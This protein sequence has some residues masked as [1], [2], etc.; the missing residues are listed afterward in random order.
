MS[1]VEPAFKFRPDD[2]DAP[3]VPDPAL[4]SPRLIEIK[5]A[6]VDA[7]SAVFEEKKITYAEYEKFR[8]VLQTL[9]EIKGVHGWFDIW[10]AKMVDETYEDE[11]VGTS[12]QPEGP[13][14]FPGAPSLTPVGPDYSYALPQREGEPGTP[15]IIS[16]QVRSLDGTPLA[17]AEF[18]VWQCADTGIY[19]NFGMDDQPEFNL[20]GKFRCD[21]DGRYELR[22]I[23]PVPYMTPGIPQILVDIWNGLGKAHFRPAHVHMKVRHD[24]L[25]S[26]EYMTQMYFAGDP[27]LGDNDPG[28]NSLSS[29][30]VSPEK[31]TDP[32]ELTARGLE[33]YSSFLTVTFDIVVA[34]AP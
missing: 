25:P 21:S 3:F 6:L 15:L 22:T 33:G 9:Q 20:R 28:E 26:G 13:L 29:L 1:T 11:W 32:A 4:L 5:Q 10:L 19:S 14:Y 30:E 27:Y 18:D 17:N 2:P 24:D 8:Q 12:S 16:G 23:K 34:T 31:H 7:V